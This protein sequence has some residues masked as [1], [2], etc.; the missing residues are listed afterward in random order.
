VSLPPPPGP[1]VY[2]PAPPAVPGQIVQYRLS[3]DDVRAISRQRIGHPYRA[4]SVRAGDTLAAI[5]VRILDDGAH[6]LHVFLDGPDTYWA[7][8]VEQGTQD[9]TWSWPTA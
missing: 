7:Q 8:N 5:V 2:F 1:V 9:G 6:N 4:P 3:A